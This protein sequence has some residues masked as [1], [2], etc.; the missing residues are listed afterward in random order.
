[1]SFPWL[2]HPGSG[3]A[4]VMTTLLVMVTLAAAVKFLLD[5]VSVNV[6]GYVI[7][8]GHM[9]SLSYGA[10]LAPVF[11]AHGFISTRNSEGGD[12]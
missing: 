4:D 5:G 2:K 11:G 8:I 3:N 6:N 12:K 9:D 1:M 7:A 10:I